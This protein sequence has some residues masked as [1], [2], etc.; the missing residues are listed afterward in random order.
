MNAAMMKRDITNM[1]RQ[2]IRD[3]WGVN[4]GEAGV[5]DKN[6]RH[7]KI[8]ALAGL[9]SEMIFFGESVG[10]NGVTLATTNMEENGKLPVGKDFLLEGF[11]IRPFSTHATEATRLADLVKLLNTGVLQFNYMDKPR[12]ADGPLINF[13]A[14]N[15]LIGV[16]ATTGDAE[17]V[18][19]MLRN[20]ILIEGGKNF[21]L[22]LLWK[23][24]GGSP[25]LTGDVELDVRLLGQEIN[26][27]TKVGA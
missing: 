15:T 1:S 13:V 3:R 24:A 19:Y 7:K 14:K 21:S 2:Q 17:P 8:Y 16:D 12:F 18:Y 20:P 9:I 26:S 27:A 25:A 11:E 5:Q 4:D 23:A 10:N 22:A 6:L